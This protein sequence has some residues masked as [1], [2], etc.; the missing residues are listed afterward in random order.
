MHRG[1]CPGGFDRGLIE[2]VSYVPWREN[3]DYHLKEGGY[4]HFLHT[5]YTVQLFDWKVRQELHCTG[6]C[7]P[8]L[9]VWLALPCG[10]PRQQNVWSNT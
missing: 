3:L 1:I 2:R 10:Q 9:A 6:F 8:K 5:L 4:I 7:H